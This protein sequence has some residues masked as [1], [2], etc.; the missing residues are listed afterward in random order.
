MCDVEARIATD[1]VGAV[2]DERSASVRTSTEVPATMLQSSNQPD[3]NLCTGVGIGALSTKKH[4][5]SYD[6]IV[7]LVCR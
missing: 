5:T 1:Q 7:L 6:S 2:L 3:W 4:K